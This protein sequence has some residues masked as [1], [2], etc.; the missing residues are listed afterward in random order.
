[1]TQFTLTLIHQL[2][3]L[4]G[5]RVNLFRDWRLVFMAIGGICLLAA[6]MIILAVAVEA[7]P[8]PGLPQ[9]P[10]DRPE[11]SMILKLPSQEPAI[12]SVARQTPPQNEQRPRLLE[13]QRPRLSEP[14]SISGPPPTPKKPRLAIVIDDMGFDLHKTAQLCVLDYPL[15]LS[16][17]PYVDNVQLQADLAMQSGHE[18]MLHLPMEP[19]HEEGAEQDPGP[20][21]LTLAMSDKELKQKLSKN[22]A[23]FTGYIGVNNHMGSRLTT[24]SHA[25]KLI[26]RELADQDLFFLD[27]VTHSGTRVASVAR[28]LSIP[29]LSRSV[30]LDSEGPDLVTP[31]LIRTRIGQA[32]D[33]AHR[34][35]SAIVIGHPYMVTIEALTQWQ[36]NVEE[37][38]IELVYASD[39]LPQTRQTTLARRPPLTNRPS[40]R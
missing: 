38:G 11:R 28:E 22:L 16:F 19:M 25:M 15:T 18:V 31:E 2:S 32:I 27:S 9:L 8:G 23:S 5:G 21:A 35:G 36:P 37:L 4:K 30:F 7:T 20:N 29:V 1:M 17:L 6:Y 13:P 26:L 24:D 10:P 40:L 34:E 33:I 14:F 12:V 39:L 3:R